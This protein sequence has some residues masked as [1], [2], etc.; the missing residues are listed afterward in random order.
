MMHKRKRVN[1][2]NI[3]I[4]ANIYYAFTVL[5]I[6]FSNSSCTHIL[7]RE[8]AGTYYSVSKNAA[9]SSTIKLTDDTSFIYTFDISSSMGV[10]TITGKWKIRGRNL[11]VK[12]GKEN[13]YK[14][15]PQNENSQCTTLHCYDKMTGDPIYAVGCFRVIG[16]YQDF[17]LTDTNGYLHIDGPFDSIK[18]FS[19]WIDST[20]IDKQFQYNDIFLFLD[21]KYHSYPSIAK[22]YKICCRKNRLYPIQGTD[23]I[24]Y[25]QRVP[26]LDKFVSDKKQKD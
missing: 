11:F 7:Y 1:I 21:T 14:I 6:L 15:C 24:Q 25:Y 3:L 26:T 8:I 12:C 16:E 4:Q 13:E 10:D 17:F 23:Y 2:I 20:L 5:F 18:C 19:L 9:I 22:R